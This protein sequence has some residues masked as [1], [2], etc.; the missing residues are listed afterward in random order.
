ML[1]D[2]PR[3]L[4]EVRHRFIRLAGEP[5]IPARP[6]PSRS[7]DPIASSLAN[8]SASIPPRPPTQQARPKASSR[9]ICVDSCETRDRLS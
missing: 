1:F 2:V 9:S 5:P 3:E 6:T 4:F 8:R 7:R